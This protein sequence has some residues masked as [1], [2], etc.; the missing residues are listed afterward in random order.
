VTSG[1]VL[2]FLQKALEAR[3]S[4]FDARH[5]TAF[6]LFNGFIEGE[7]ILVVDLYASTLVIHNY[8]DDP[9]Q[10]INLLEQAAQ[11]FQDQLVWLRAGI[12]KTRNANSQEEKRGQVLFGSAPD[13]KIKELGVWYSVDLTMNRDA[14]FYLDTR[15]LRK[16]LIETMSGK[17]VLN[18][19]AYTGSLGVAAQAGGAKRVVQHDLNRQ[20]LNVAKTSYTLNGF[21]IHKQDFIA[22]DFFSLVSKLKH[23]GE[24][25]DC[26]IIDPPFFSTTS[27]GKVDQINESARLINK[28]RPLITDGGI[29]IAIN[30]ALY[31]SGKEYIQ[32]LEELCKDGYLRIEGLIPVPEDFTGYP[33]TRTSI[34]I[35]DPAPFNHSTKIAVLGVKRKDV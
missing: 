5:E 22:A 9:A 4:L 19:F 2:P 34:P 11:F 29:L 14:S 23:T 8:A 10:G 7:P 30:N 21:P 20:F 3:G 32:T 17:T 18:T 12:V 24:T 26:V 33:E 15:N 28:V 13:T 35:T 6:R 1:F 16:W 27:K 25:F 31:L